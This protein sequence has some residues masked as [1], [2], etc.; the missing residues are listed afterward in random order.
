MEIQADRARIVDEREQMPMVTPPIAD[1]GAFAPPPP[2]VTT[3]TIGSETVLTSRTS[4]FTPESIVAGVA[5]VGLLLLGGI[6]A[7]R[8]G[9]DSSLDQPV[10]EVAGYTAT[11]LLGLIELV[12]GLV[13]LSAVLTRAHSSVLFLGIAGA[14]MALVA[15]FQPSV[16]EGSLAIERGFAVVVAVVMAAVVAAALLPTVR[17]RTVVRRTSDVT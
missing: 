4:G 15:V 16:G 7:A 9:I 6:T 10:V 5:A 13:L 14:V 12:F 1:E 11:A 17:R 2:L 8:A 3:R